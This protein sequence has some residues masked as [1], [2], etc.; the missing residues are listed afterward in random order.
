MKKTALIAGA[1]GLV[2]GILLD[3]ILASNYY[4]KVVVLTRAPLSHRHPLL[5]NIVVD[6]DNLSESCAGILVDDVFC[7]LGTTM[8]KA[9]SKAAFKKVDYDYVV[10]LADIMKKNGAKQFMVITAM[11]ADK[12]SA[13][14]YN[15]IKGLTEESLLQMGMP[16]LHI[17]RPS[18]IIGAREEQR[19]GESIA[20][21]ILPY[22]D[23]F[24]K[25]SFK[26]YATV[27]ASAIA[28]KML[29]LAQQNISGGYIH[30]S[31]SIH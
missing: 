24:M 9:G 30:L 25:G 27:P 1:S 6:F 8:K 14:Y 12:G 5:E 23:I 21:T 22:F 13:I 16:T 15:K 2:G 20:Q 18:L 11:G 4:S 19:I 3:K 28:D 7:C 31:D 10:A 26:K 17:I 29:T